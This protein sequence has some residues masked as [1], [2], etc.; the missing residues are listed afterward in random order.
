MDFGQKTG[1]F[2]LPLHPGDKK[3]RKR[4]ISLIKSMRGAALKIDV[5]S[6]N[7]WLVAIYSISLEN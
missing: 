4:D 5:R 3:S 6:V 7:T 2:A 1:V